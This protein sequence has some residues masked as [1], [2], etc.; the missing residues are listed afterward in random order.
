MYAYNIKT[1]LKKKSKKSS[2]I[3]GFPKY[4]KRFFCLYFGAFL[5]GRFNVWLNLLSK[6]L[7]LHNEYSI[8][9]GFYYFFFCF[10]F[11]AIF[12]LTWHRGAYTVNF[13]YFILYFFQLKQLFCPREIYFVHIIYYTYAS[14]ASTEC[15]NLLFHYFGIK[16]ALFYFIFDFYFFSG[17]SIWV[18]FDK[19]CF[20]F[21]FNF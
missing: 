1:F 2:V 3:C 14:E 11:L 16:F 9:I 12:Y 21:I 7:I 10:C 19:M 18:C 5:F 4:C 17:K 15:L 13:L 6:T 8:C 20:F